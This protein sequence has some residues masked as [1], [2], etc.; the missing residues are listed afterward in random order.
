MC[1]RQIQLE[2]HAQ[3]LES[4]NETRDPKQLF[5]AISRQIHLI[6]PHDFMS[7]T[8]YDPDR[9]T[10]TILYASDP[11]RFFNQ[12]EIFTRDTVPIQFR[13]AETGEP[14]VFD[15][16]RKIS[17]LHPE[18][19][20]RFERTG[21]R[22]SLVYPIRR[23]PPYTDMI[24]LTSREIAAFNSAHL[25]G[26]RQIEPH[27]SR[28]IQQSDA[29]STLEKAYRDIQQAQESL[30]Q[31]EREKAALDT[32]LQ[33]GL[34]LSHEINN[35]LTAI[36]GFAELLTQE[37]PNTP[38]FKIILDAG[39]RIAEVV[40]RLRQIKTVQLQ[41]YISDIPIQMIELGLSRP[42]GEGNRPSLLDK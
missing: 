16:V 41:T 3:F 33:T 37:H 19:R 20:K 25:D 34:T 5:P 4:L 7:V 2:T 1:A 6:V 17:S 38:E 42:A 12:G 36:I 26:L 10:V 9:E 21:G 32:A 13:T 30:I 22:S 18:L 39:H 29:L 14:A 15:D 28:A 31:K 35:P 27:I 23:L 24:I 8:R 40:R 11:D